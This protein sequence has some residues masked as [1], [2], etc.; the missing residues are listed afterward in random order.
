MRRHL[1]W[2]LLAGVGVL[3]FSGCGD[4][5]GTGGAG[6]TP[7]TGGTP[8]TGGDNAGGDNAGGDNAGGDNA[9]GDNA[10][11]EGGGAMTN[12]LENSHGGM[13][14]GQWMALYWTWSLGGDQGPSE[15]D[16]TFLPLPDATDED[17]DMVFTGELDFELP[18]GQGFVLPMFVWLGET[19]EGGDPPDDDPSMP[20]EAFF[21]G[22]DLV[23]TLDGEVL[24][25]SADGNL[26]D[27]YTD[28]EDFAETITYATPTDYGAV[29]PMWVKGVGVL[30]APLATGAHVLHLEE[31]NSDAGVGYSNTWNITVP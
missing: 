7:N 8:S 11:G 14:L 19:Y 13:D 22:M 1:L 27:Y 2:G 25:D 12:G 6:G 20:P 26:A 9:G 21:T 24:L 17:G 10:G 15:G 29:G 5:T 16:R 30:H 31:L 18:A 4:D 23:L 28:A 3:A